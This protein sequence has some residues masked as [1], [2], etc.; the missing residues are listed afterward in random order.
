MHYCPIG[1]GLSKY[2]IQLHTAI[3]EAFFKHSRLGPDRNNVRRNFFVS[4]EQGKDVAKQ[5]NKGM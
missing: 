3:P 1:K 2:S 5:D 4:G